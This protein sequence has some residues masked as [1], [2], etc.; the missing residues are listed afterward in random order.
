MILARL[1]MLKFWLRLH[2][3]IY[4]SILIINSTGTVFVSR[5]RDHFIC[6][7]LNSV[8][9]ATKRVTMNIRYLWNVDY[10]LFPKMYNMRL[11]SLFEKKKK[12]QLPTSLC[13]AGCHF[14]I[15]SQAASAR[16]QLADAVRTN[17]NLYIFLT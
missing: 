16:L 15:G 11:K 3:F 9:L 4:I 10:L 7:L 1:C 2:T 6:D 8:V 13:C 5:T 14:V 17:K 12:I